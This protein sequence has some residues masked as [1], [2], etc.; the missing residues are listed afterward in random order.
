MILTSWVTSSSP[1][2]VQTPTEQHLAPLTSVMMSWAR[3]RRPDTH[4][5][6][7]E[8]AMVH[9]NINIWLQGKIPNFWNTKYLVI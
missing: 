4:Y 8:Q 7:T 5:N 3:M 6:N 2:H 1:L 9:S